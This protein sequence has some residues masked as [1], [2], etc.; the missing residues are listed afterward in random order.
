MSDPRRWPAGRSAGVRE[1]DTVRIVVDRVNLTGTIDLVGHG[2]ECCSVEEGAAVLASRPLHPDLAPDEVLSD[3]TRL[4]A[5]LQNVSG[6]TWGGCVF[7]VDRI[8]KLL[9]AGERALS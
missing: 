8:V 9:E 5:A 3:D 6:G 1:G 7:D 2:G 4:W